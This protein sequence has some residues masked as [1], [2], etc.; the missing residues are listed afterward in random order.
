MRCHFEVTISLEKIE[1]V[2]TR[3]FF[4]NIEIL[5]FILHNIFHMYICSTSLARRT[6]LPFLHRRR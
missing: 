2:A 5:A 1:R 3:P 4:K 6:R